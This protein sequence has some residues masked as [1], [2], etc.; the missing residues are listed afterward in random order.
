MKFENSIENN[1]SKQILYSVL[2][3]LVFFSSYLILGYIA[4]RIIVGIVSGLINGLVIF[5]LN[6]V[7]PVDKFWTPLETKREKIN[8]Y[9]W[10]SSVLFFTYLTYGIISFLL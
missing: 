4:E 7:I 10:W 5:W 3:G 2:F 1:R 8:N 6:Y 9:I